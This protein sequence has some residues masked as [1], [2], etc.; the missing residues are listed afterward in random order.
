MRCGAYEQRPRVCRIYPAEVNPFVELMPSAKACPP[1][2]WSDDRPVL[3][4]QGRLVD[5]ETDRLIRLS[6]E[7]DR[8]DACAKERLCLRLGISAAA[9]ANEGFTVY[10]ASRDVIIP[11][12]K[13]AGT[14]HLDQ[15]DRPEWT[16]VSNRQSTV[17]ALVSV[18]ALSVNAADTMAHSFEYIGFYPEAR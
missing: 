11:A 18:G 5:V 3:L 2:A 14:A 17:D 7:A 4:E 8:N 12:L 15:A 10:S 6:R 16:L 13:Q 9:I 1:E